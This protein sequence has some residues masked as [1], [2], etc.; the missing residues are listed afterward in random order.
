MKRP[1][2]AVG[3]ALSLAC[4]YAAVRGVDWPTV[5]AALG[6][7]NPLG[8]LVPTACYSLFFVL[9][10]YRWQRFVAPLAP[11][12][13]GPFLSATLIGFMANN[14]L[15]LRLGE[16]I[17]G[18]ALS[19]LTPVRLSTALATAVLERVWDVF[20]VALLLV[21]VLPRF[22]LP[23]GLARANTLMLAL[24]VGCLV[25]GWW[26]VR[27]AGSLRLAWLPERLAGL[28]RHGVD[29]LRAL[30]HL[31]LLVQTVVLSLATWLSVAGYYWLLLR[32][33]GLDL[34]LEAGLVVMLA[35]AVGVAL[36]AAPGF[37]GTFQYAVVFALSLF[38][39]PR[40]EALSFSIIAHVAQLLPVILGGFIALLRSG[41]PLWPS[42]LLPAKDG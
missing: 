10:A 30:E 5:L 16:L 9:R 33:C 19:R 31:S 37:I 4:G 39:V 6:R 28:V 38:S 7:I 17:R 24:G 25:A 29:G 1:P 22:P 12:P 21:W 32:A 36:P 20:V 8:L 14:V 40:E 11:L 3:L 41:L 26:G 23:D 15:P 27:H 2:I 18:Y 35:V 34:P 42:R 13:V